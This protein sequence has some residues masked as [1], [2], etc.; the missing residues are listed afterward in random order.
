MPGSCNEIETKPGAISRKRGAGV[1]QRGG[2]PGGA[3]GAHRRRE[4]E[5]S[6][7]ARQA[8]PSRGF[9]DRLRDAGE[10]SQPETSGF[11][12]TVTAPMSPNRELAHNFGPS[13]LEAKTF[14]EQT[15][16]IWSS[17]APRRTATKPRC[18]RASAG[19]G[20]GGPHRLRLQDV[21]Q[22]LATLP[23]LPRHRGVHPGPSI[24]S[25][26]APMA[27]PERATTR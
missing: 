1:Q 8:H 25:T 3:G 23:A 15:F 17:V 4:P 18:F 5:Q 7:L 19:P 20:L 22:P 6:A 27:A 21:R 2:Q 14:P 12:S 24:F 11:A 10:P 16:T 13:R 9:P 26:L